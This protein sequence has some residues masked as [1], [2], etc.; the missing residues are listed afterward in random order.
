MTIK[1][2]LIA[3]VSIP[4]VSDLLIDKALLDNDLTGSATYAKSN[5]LSVDLAAISV[6]FGALQTS[7]V[8]EGGFSLSINYEAAKQNLI[9]LAGRNVGNA[10]ADEALLLYG[11]GNSVTG[12]SPW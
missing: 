6:L 4:S 5:A 11:E 2:A 9:S 7:S 10:V 1:Q 8:S 3:V 12:I